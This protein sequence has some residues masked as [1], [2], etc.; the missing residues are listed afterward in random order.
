MRS[1]APCRSLDALQV[2]T[3]DR[4]THGDGAHQFAPRHLWQPAMLLLFRSIGQNVVGHDAVNPGAELNARVNK[5]FNHYGFVGIS[6]AAS[7]VFFGNV[8]Q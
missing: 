4:F 3:S 6:A 5:L 8:R 2:R 1:V 7:P